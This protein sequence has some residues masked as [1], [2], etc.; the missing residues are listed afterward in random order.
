MSKLILLVIILLLAML[1]G[2]LLVNNPGYV[3]IIVAGYT[4][5]MT[6]L[7]LALALFAGAIVLTV[8]LVIIKKLARWQH[9]SFNF[10]RSRRQRKARQAFANGLQAYA[11]QQWQLASEQLQSALAEPSYLTEKRM[12][13]SYA[14][15]YAGNSKAATELAAALIADDSN[16][17]FVQA[18]LLLQQGLAGQACKLLAPQL[19]AA[20]DD[21][22]LGQ[23][24]LQALQQAGQWRQLLQTV[25]QAINQRWFSKAQWQQQRFAL[26]PAAL[27]QLS[28]QHGFSEE[29]DY[30]QALPGKERK[31]AAAMLGLAWAQA[32]AGLCEPAEQKL[33]QALTFADLPAAW[34]YLRQ[35][36]LGLSVL[37]LRKAA[38]HWLRDNPANGYVFAVLAYLAEQ[39]GDKDQA[40]LAWQKVR[41]YQPDLC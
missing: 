3:K 41:Q 21:K 40:A 29:A 7:G 19:D 20:A 39:E 38:Q 35:I 24:Y 34:P 12:L 18:D 13:A 8:C 11:R 4:L 10:F 9:L 27:S 33:V 14:S 26:Y 30:W 28:L 2:P 36:P 37:K 16:S 23:L 1:F 17:A 6:L 5:E 15:F 32:Q 25:P 31:S 22:A